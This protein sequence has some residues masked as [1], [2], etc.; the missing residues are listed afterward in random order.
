MNPLAS[1]SLCSLWSPSACVLATIRY[2]LSTLIAIS[3]QPIKSPHLATSLCVECY[4]R[5]RVIMVALAAVNAHLPMALKSSISRSQRPAFFDRPKYYSFY[6]RLPSLR[7]IQQGLKQGATVDI[8]SL[9][10]LCP[11]AEGEPTGKSMA[12][13]LR[14]AHRLSTPL[15]QY[16][17]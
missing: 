3:I 8:C 16:G 10:G 4:L 7:L 17:A 5:L 6:C 14:R 11:A 1:S 2:G 13:W 15:Q 9:L 12:K